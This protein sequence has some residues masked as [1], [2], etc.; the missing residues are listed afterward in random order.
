GSGELGTAFWVGNGITLVSL[1]AG[2]LMAMTPDSAEIRFIPGA[3]VSLTHPSDLRADSGSRP[4]G[5][6]PGLSLAMTF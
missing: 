3:P 2:M 5:F 6:D 4:R 1:L